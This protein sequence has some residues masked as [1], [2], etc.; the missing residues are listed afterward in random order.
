MFYQTAEVYEN[1]FKFERILPGKYFLSGYMDLNH[2]QAFDL[3]LVNPY[4]PM[5]PFA[6]YPD[7]IYVRSRW[8]T[9]GIEL[10]F[11]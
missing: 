4:S 10:K 11:H 2:N 5:E 3:G 8:E 1:H 7:T 6:V 9:E